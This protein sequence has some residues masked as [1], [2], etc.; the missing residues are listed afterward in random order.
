MNYLIDYFIRGGWVMYPLLLCSIFALAI[1]F[2]KI[3]EFKRIKLRDTKFADLFFDALQNKDVALALNNLALSPS[4]IALVMKQA[5]KII[6]EKK[7]S[8]PDIEL[9]I[10]RIGEE[11]I[12]KLS[13]GIRP[14]SF[15]VTISPVLGL[16]GTVIG[17]I[18]VF[19]GIE[20][21]GNQINPAM[22]GGGIWKALLTTAFGLIIAIPYMGIY[23]YLDGE[24][25]KAK[26]TM[27]NNVIKILTI[28]KNA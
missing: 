13:T 17:M 4:P 1:T 26:I 11:Q 22:L 12:N 6:S 18:D 10:N 23:H 16:F 27:K 28:L 2:C 9:E 15:I 7:L 24:I 21:S 19:Q 3:F 5:T 25:E 8:E 20:N 14:L